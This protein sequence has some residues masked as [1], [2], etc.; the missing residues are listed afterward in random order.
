MKEGGSAASGRPEYL[1]K[2]VRV[3]APELD[4]QAGDSQGE[5]FAFS[6]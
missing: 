2:E 4:G 3:Q 1:R 6:S 5:A